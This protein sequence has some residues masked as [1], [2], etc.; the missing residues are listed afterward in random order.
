MGTPLR[1]YPVSERWNVWRTYHRT[2]IRW[3]RHCRRRIH[4]TVC[5]FRHLAVASRHTHYCNRQRYQPWRFGLHLWAVYQWPCSNGCLLHQRRHNGV[6]LQ[7]LHPAL[8]VRPCGRIFFTRL[9]Q[10]EWIC[11]VNPAWEWRPLYLWCREAWLLC[12]LAAT[13]SCRHRSRYR[14]LEAWF[15]GAP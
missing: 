6:Y 3:Y 8:G 9:V 2:T 12:R 1:A 5:F 14:H 10:A 7:E 13:H 11:M 4:I 15:V